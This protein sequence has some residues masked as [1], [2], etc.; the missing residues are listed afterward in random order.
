MQKGGP[1]L[2]AGGLRKE[3]EAVLLERAQYS[4]FTVPEEVNN[5]SRCPRG[6]E[7]HVCPAYR[8]V[9]Y[10]SHVAGRGKPRSGSGHSTRSEAL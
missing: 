3:V 8:Q 9:L 4:H 7:L 10:Y 6:T 2:G 1:D 5:W